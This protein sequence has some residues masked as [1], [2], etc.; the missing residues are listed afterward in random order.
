MLAGPPPPPACHRCCDHGRAE[1]AHAFEQ[2]TLAPLHLNLISRHPSTCTCS[3]SCKAPNQLP[4]GPGTALAP[5][6]PGGAS[7]LPRSVAGAAHLQTLLRLD[8]HCLLHQYYYS[9]GKRLYK[10]CR[11]SGYTTLNFRSLLIPG[12]KAGG[13]SARSQRLVM[14]REPQIIYCQPTR[15]HPA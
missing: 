10:N 3:L 7:S 15:P 1:S 8:H 12:V 13:S 2:A 6:C 5:P 14:H 4:A 11:N 9:E